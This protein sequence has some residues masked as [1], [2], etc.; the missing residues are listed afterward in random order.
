[1]TRRRSRPF[2]LA[3][4]FRALADPTRREILDHLRDGPLTTGDLVGRFGLSRVGV[5]K[6]LE[7][8]VRAGLVSVRREGRQRWNQLNPM[9]IHQLSRRWIKPFETLPAERLLRLKHHAEAQQE[10]PMVEAAKFQSVDIQLEVEIAARPEVVWASLTSRIGEWWPAKFYVGT[11][12]KR[13]TL[14][15]HVG[16]RVYEDWGDGEGALFGTLTAFEQNRM[17][18]WAGDMSADF[19]GPARSVTTF[20]L[21]KGAKPGSTLLS[22]RDT[23]FGLLSDVAMTGLEQGWRWLL[24]ECFRPYVEQG[25]RPERP[26]SVVA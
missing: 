22:F 26:E 1:M 3:P 9:P 5:M 6:H 12:P 15:P 8:L 16:G 19:G 11:S 25:K 7:I 23:P 20:R 24:T 4:V 18:Q 2:E 13:F 21:K 10:S 17:L 14:E